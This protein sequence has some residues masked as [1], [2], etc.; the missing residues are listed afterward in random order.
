MGGKPRAI[1][2]R[3]ET[4]SLCGVRHSVLS[5]DSFAVTC[6]RCIAAMLR[7]GLRVEQD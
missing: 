4:G 2:L 3:T 6:A 5:W 7:A 1:G